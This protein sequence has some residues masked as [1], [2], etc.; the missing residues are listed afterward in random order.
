M[1]KRIVIL[2]SMML[3]CVLAVCA[4]GCKKSKEEET[5]E[6]T[7]QA[8]SEK[9]EE[10]TTEIDA[11][12]SEET[13]PEKPEPLET[14]VA[15]YE[16]LGAWYCA[17]DGVPV[18]LELDEDGSYTLTI[19]EEK[20]EG[21]WELA[22]GDLVLD[23]NTEAPM[24]IIEGERILWS[25]AG[26]VFKREEVTV[27]EPAPV[28]DEGIEPEYFDGYWVSYYVETEGKRLPSGVA[29]D[30]S[31]LFIDAGR[32]AM[33]GALF[34]D[35][36]CDFTYDDGSY[37][38]ENDAGHVTLQLQDDGMLRCT[39]TGENSELILYMMEGDIESLPIF[40][41]AEEEEADTEE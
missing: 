33:G 22:D 12:P 21:T 2:I 23:G 14:P 5:E 27:F 28:A 32:V 24:Q 6:T 25:E 17:H 30:N 18:C 29:G 37:T 13:E 15:G 36:V 31:A 19:A 10:P 16:L 1:K 11:A 26:E 41:D 7:T 35:I 34:G 4:A 39:V 9:S 40:A 38:Y 3:I 20:S 8:V